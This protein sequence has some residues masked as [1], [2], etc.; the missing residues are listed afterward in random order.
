MTCTAKLI[1]LTNL[2]Q[3]PFF[4]F[5]LTVQLNNESILFIH[6]PVHAG[7]NSNNFQFLLQCIY[8]VHS[9][10]SLNMQLPDWKL[11]HP[12]GYTCEIR[13]ERLEFLQM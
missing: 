5:F 13:L 11:T 12:L 3:Q 10:K 1:V 6:D 9:I 2:R 7:S 8:C 4:F